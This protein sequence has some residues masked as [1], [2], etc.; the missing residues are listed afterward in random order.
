MRWRKKPREIAKRGSYRTRSGFLFY[1]KL[2]DDEWRWLERTKWDQVMMPNGCRGEVQKAWDL[3]NSDK[4]QT[5]E[6][7]GYNVWH[8]ITWTV[9]K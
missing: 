1:P 5:F 4:P 8:D 3:L 9:D 2:I 6:Y 7:G